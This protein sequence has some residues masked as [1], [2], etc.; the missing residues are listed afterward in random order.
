[1]DG[2]LRPFTHPAHRDMLLLKVKLNNDQTPVA[3][4]TQLNEAL[5]PS[6]NQEITNYNQN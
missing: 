6:P 4:Q 3:Q 1:M 2:L 5:K